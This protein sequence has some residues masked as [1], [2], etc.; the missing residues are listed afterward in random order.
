M[1]FRNIIIESAAQISV[2]NNQL[3]IK[4]DT[5]H[6]IAIEDISALLLENRQSNITVAALSQLGQS[7]C[8]VYICD[9][10]HMPCAVTTPFSQHSRQLEMIKTQTSASLPTRKRL[11]Q[12][13]IVSKVQNQAR[14]MQLSGKPEAANH[15]EMLIPRIRSGDPENIEAVAAA[16]Y[17]PQLFGDRF[18]RS[19]DGGINSA[20]NYSYAIL[21]GAVARNLAVYGFI[22]ALGLFHHGTLNSFN[23]ADDLMEPFRPVADYLVSTSINDD[24]PLTPHIKRTL[25]NILNLDII[26]GGQRHSISYAA[27]RL[28][29]SL[30]RSLKDSSESLLLP[31]MIE[32]SQHTY[33]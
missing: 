18:T 25:F 8:A 3:V 27:E 10:K 21:R 7:G 19:F 22:P 13:I 30:S 16:Y 28:V 29:Q 6:R 1:S 11:W 17:F 9:E 23:L 33:E 14:C 24:E 12:S 32:L 4:T 26:S 2:K 5:E 20:L 31:E 15:L